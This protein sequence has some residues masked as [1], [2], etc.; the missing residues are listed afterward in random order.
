MGKI[1]TLNLGSKHGQISKWLNIS[2][3]SKK[4]A[5]ITIDGIIGGDIWFLDDDSDDAKV[6]RANTKKAMRNEL[7][8]I[9]DL[10][11][12]KIIVDIDSPGGLV[13]HA[14]SMHDLL[15]SHP[16]EVETDI[17]G[18][19]GSSATIVS[20]SAD[21]GLRRI[22]DNAMFLPHRV[23]GGAIGNADQIRDEADNIEKAEKRLVNIYAKRSGRTR[24]Q[25]QKIMN[26]NSG[27]G[28][29]LTAKEAKTEGLVDEVYEPATPMAA[30]VLKSAT[31]EMLNLPKLPKAN[32]NSNNMKILNLVTFIALLN[33]KL[34][35]TATKKRKKNAIIE[36]IADD[37]EVEESEVKAIL[38]G[39]VTKK[40][41][42]TLEAMAS[43]FG[44]TLKS[45]VAEANGVDPEDEG[46]EEEEETNEEGSESN[47]KK[48]LNFLKDTFNIGDKITRKNLRE[49]AKEIAGEIEEDYKDEAEDLN[50]EIDSLKAQVATLKQKKNG[51]KGNQL[52]LGGEEDEDPGTDKEDNTGTLVLESMSSE[53]RR[54]LKNNKK[55][56]D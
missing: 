10:N 44:T 9:S 53:Q 50:E 8:A 37:A 38:D 17:T 18:M 36:E 19:T 27:E 33:S 14:L 40:D 12:E 31:R 1:K 32:K 13:S 46:E 34:V 15:A 3:D 41:M 52:D 29:W 48:V 5:R 6:R 56:D 23:T 28:E 49:A 2:N 39:K 51:K 26:K 54:R 47:Y 20:Q 30:L 24:A 35:E 4:I 25:I 21:K 11:V 43:I 45:L 55:K 7:Q 22:S 42:A 16:A